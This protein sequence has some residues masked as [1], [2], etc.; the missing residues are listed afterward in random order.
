MAKKELNLKGYELAVKGNIIVIETDSG[1]YYSFR[2]DLEP[3]IISAKRG[4]LSV[5]EEKAGR[6]KKTYCFLKFVDYEI[7]IE[8]LT[9]AHAK[10]LAEELEEIYW[11]EN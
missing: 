6:A 2:K 7:W 9:M 8:C 3:T 10:T 4:S 11:G 1:E 5:T